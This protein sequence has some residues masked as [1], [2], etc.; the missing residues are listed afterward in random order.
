LQWL[1]WH[2]HKAWAF[3]RPAASA[4]INASATSEVRH[5]SKTASLSPLFS[6]AGTFRYWKIRWLLSESV[7]IMGKLVHVI[8]CRRLSRH[9]YDRN[10]LYAILFHGA[11]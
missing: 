8:H 11:A 5:S 9:I 6:F 1:S 2:C 4:L 7:V 3:W 10:I